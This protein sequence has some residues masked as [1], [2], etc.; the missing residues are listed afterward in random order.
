MSF[1]LAVLLGDFYLFKNFQSQE[2]WHMRRKIT[3]TGTSR[4]EVC[5]KFFVLRYWFG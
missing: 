3:D 2:V 5:L 1:K 4:S